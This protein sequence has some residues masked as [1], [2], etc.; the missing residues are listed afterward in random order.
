M[1]RAYSIRSPCMGRRPA[2]EVE[3]GILAATSCG[4]KAACNWSSPGIALKRI[5]VRT[6]AG[7]EQVD[8]DG[9]LLGLVGIAGDHGFQRGLGRG[10]DAPVGARPRNDCRWSRTARGRPR[11]RAAAG[12]TARMRRQ[13]AVKLT[14]RVSCERG[15][16]DLVLQRA[17]RAEHA[18]IW[19][20]DRRGGRS[21]RAG[22]RRACRS[23][24]CRAGR[25]GSAWRCGRWRP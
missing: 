13:L 1:R 3:G 23:R 5:S 15:G 14:S 24:P 8:A 18:G 7:V 10:I 25:A 19:P 17:Q 22:R 12:A 6:C 4:V 20:T 11:S 21:A 16:R 2:G 9:R